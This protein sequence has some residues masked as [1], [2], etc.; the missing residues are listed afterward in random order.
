[1]KTHGRHRKRASAWTAP[2]LSAG[3]VLSGCASGVSEGA[4]VATL[5]RLAPLMTAH[6]RALAGEDVAAMRATGRAVIATY[7]AGRG[8]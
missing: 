3:I 7:D 8:R 6:A 4:A 5:D 2:I 1:M